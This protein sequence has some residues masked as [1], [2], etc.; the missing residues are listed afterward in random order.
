MGIAITQEQRE[1]AEA[2][3]GWLARTAPVEQTRKLLDA[4]EAAVGRPPFWDGLAEQGLL[5]IHLGEEFGGGGLIELAVV[6]EEA[7]RG[8]L[9]G[10]YLPGVLAAEL[11]RRDGR[12]EALVA[13]IA[14]G[15][16]TAA[17]A[18]DAGTLTAVED[19]GGGY[20]VYYAI[21]DV[22]AFVTPGGAVDAE[23]H[24]RV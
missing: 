23:A 12:H 15:R 3:R 8:L 17:V 9:P 18:L 14:E 6:L 16:A 24:R 10:P 21:A 5:G 7:G 2:V 11:L 19:A 13:D 1:L 20:R 22:A 4:P